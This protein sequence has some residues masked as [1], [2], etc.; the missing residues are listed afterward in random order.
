MIR[1][2]QV[3]RFK[4]FRHLD[5]TLGRLTVLSGLNSAGKTSV[6]HALLLLR[7]AAD[8]RVVAL[9]GAFGL[10]LG[11]AADV[12]HRGSPQATIEI[13]A[14]SDGA[15]T[16][17]T[18]VL[19]VPEDRSLHLEITSRP[20]RAILSSLCAKPPAFTYLCA[21]RLGPRDTLSATSDHPEELGVGVCGELT[22]QVLALRG[23]HRVTARRQAPL[24]EGE[25]PMRALDL[26]ERQAARWL[27]RILG[28]TDSLDIDAEWL[29][30]TN[31]TRLRF[32]V[33][34]QAGEWTRPN[35][36]GF[37]VSYV[38]PIVVAGLLAPASG[39]IIVENPEAHLHPAGQ[40]AMGE[41]L[42]RVADD[43]VQVVIETHSDHVVN[44]VRRAVAERRVSLDPAEVAIRFFHEPTD[45]GASFVAI[46]LARTG[47]LS[48]WP[49]GF[50]DQIERDLGAIARARRARR[51]G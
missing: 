20:D 27:A 28:L 18:A 25:A 31:T 3:A 16:S 14:R 45:T 51:D 47:D 46:D 23:R 42:A 5:L 29:P 15:E 41:F 8:G 36:L 17:T 30:G 34:G 43:G 39:L 26:L 22:A 1:Q 44:G 2:L 11:E 32:R 10:A 9:N 37:G 13:S 48:T 40:S 19:T 38:L 6:I 4:R 12:L 49:A 50:F 35:N 21:E 24:Q 7:Q 33:G